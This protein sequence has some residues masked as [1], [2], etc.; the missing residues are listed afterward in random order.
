[1]ESS[2]IA[3]VNANDIWQEL[4]LMKSKVLA[5]LS[6]TRLVNKLTFDMEELDVSEIQEAYMKMESCFEATLEVM[7]SLSDFYIRKQDVEKWKGLDMQMRKVEEDFIMADHRNRKYLTLRKSS[8]SSGMD[9]MK[10]SNDHDTHETEC[11]VTE[12]TILQRHAGVGNTKVNRK[13]YKSLPVLTIYMQPQPSNDSQYINL[14]GNG[15]QETGH[16]NVI[17]AV[18]KYRETCQPTK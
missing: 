11:M 4:E 15:T 9:P 6:F 10:K 3:D 2:K 12:D 5:K 18:C 1:M 14:V 8:A 16:F 7:K 13:I 17:L